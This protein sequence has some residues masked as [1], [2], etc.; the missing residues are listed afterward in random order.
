VQGF[1]AAAPLE[2]LGIGLVRIGWNFDYRHPETHHSFISY[3]I[4]Y[5]VQTKKRAR[6]H[7][8]MSSNEHGFNVLVHQL[9]VYRNRS[10]SPHLGTC[11]VKEMRLFSDEIL[12][13]S[14]AIAVPRAL[15][16]LLCNR[17]NVETNEF[18]AQHR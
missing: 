15:H 1:A 12:M 17:E 5:D 9:R 8:P 16:Y 4:W 13:G 6:R 3:H 14:V 11:F 18:A 2:I 10:E 7:I